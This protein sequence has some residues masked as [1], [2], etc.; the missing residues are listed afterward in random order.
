MPTDNYGS[1]V[2]S[3]SLGLEVIHKD[4]AYDNSVINVN[5]FFLFS[6]FISGF[7][8]VTSQSCMYCAKVDFPH[9]QY[10]FYLHALDAQRA[11]KC[12]LASVTWCDVTANHRRAAH[13]IPHFTLRIPHAAVPHFTRS[14]IWAPSHNFVGLYLLNSGTYRQSEKKLVKQQYLLHMSL[15]YG[16]LRPTSA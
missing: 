15:Q 1:Q 7:R 3:R 2:C 14:P 12:R 13:S 8:K 6:T 10:A 9:V 5:V 4:C 11:V 16:K